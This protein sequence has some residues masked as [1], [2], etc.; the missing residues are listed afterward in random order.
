MRRKAI[1]FVIILALSLT[2]Q[3]QDEPL[4]LRNDAPL[5]EFISLVAND[6]G[7][8]TLTGA[9]G[10]V[11]TPSQIVVRNLHTGEFLFDA[12]SFD[13]SFETT[14]VGTLETPYQIN[15]AAS[16]PPNE[17]DSYTIFPGAGTIIQQ[18]PNPTIF[19]ASGELARGA[20]RWFAEG[21]LNRFAANV[22][23][24]VILRM[25][26]SLELPPD[27][28]AVPYTFIGE[29][30]LR[31]LTDEQGQQINLRDDLER[32][33]SS[34]LTETGIP[35]IAPLAPDIAIAETSTTIRQVDEE[36]DRLLFSLNFVGN[37]PS[38]ITQGFYVPI[39]RGRAAIADS[40]AFDW[41]DNLIFS[42]DGEGAVGDS[43]TYLPFV[44]R[45]GDVPE[46][47]TVWSVMETLSEEDKTRAELVN[48]IEH[49]P[50]LMI[51]PRGVYS[52][53]PRM[54]PFGDVLPMVPF[55][56]PSGTLQATVT[57]PDGSIDTLATDVPIRQHVV[58]NGQVSL[59]TLQENFSYDFDAYGDYTISLSGV[60]LD[61]FGNRYVGGGTYRITIAEPLTLFPSA[62]ASALFV[63]GDVVPADVTVSPAV[64]AEVVI[65]VRGAVG[66]TLQGQANRYGVF[67]DDALLRWSQLGNYVID[68]TARYSD[69]LGRLWAGSLRSVGVISTD[70]ILFGQR[71]LADEDSPTQAWFDTAIYPDDAFGVAPVVNYPYFPGDVALVPD[72][73]E[74]GIRP[75]FE[76]DSTVLFNVVRPD[77]SVRQ[78]I[79]ATGQ[80]LRFGNDE[81]LNN[82]IGAGGAGNA[83]GDI[84]FLF[85]ADFQ[86][87]IGYASA[88]IITAENSTARVLPPFRE[89]LLT[90]KDAPLDLL[91][92]PTALRAGQVVVQGE[93]RSIAGHVVPTLPADVT[94]RV[95]KPDSP[96]A[97]VPLQAN[98]FGYFALNDNVLFDQVGVWR[99][100][101]NAEF[102][103]QTS[104]GQILPPYPR[105]RVLGAEDDMFIFVVPP[106]A[107]PLNIRGEAESTVFPGQSF[108]IVADVPDGWI[109]VRAF[110]TARS[111]TYLLEQSELDVVGTTVSYRYDWNGL[112][113][114][115]PNLES[116]GAGDD[117]SASDEVTITVALTGIDSDGF[118]TATARVFTLRHNVLISNDG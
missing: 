6:D 69:E 35:I 75:A 96:A 1:I 114:Q 98:R 65:D 51:R 104:A 42:V 8:V 11:F 56:L 108:A 110:V 30:A 13:G 77:V 21:D 85:G 39:F 88:A 111:A 82:Q 37:L 25:D 105:G 70:A 109:D 40:D 26:F 38:E 116:T 71:G 61:I 4:G 45:V 92:V 14:L 32:G 107:P 90:L 68:Y 67:H 48:L 3:A 72:G 94:V 91:I 74:A 117:A 64:P 22:G 113:R 78:T 99:V 87:N 29:L 44:F 12:P 47:R 9:A 18:R 89:P 31:P 49:T 41:Y 23:D 17:R 34:T 73:D 53:E 33:W 58:E 15:V 50:A 52:L 59:S 86:N 100:G 63:V 62:L 93:R 97:E 101:L 76:S 7:T 102:R 27:A 10:S 57:R 95:S 36:S 28:L 20:S 106:D 43:A 80:D 54:L 24:E 55:S 19:T 83:A 16:F 66:G 103:G 2:L 79:I 118:P 84:L 46:I 112:A 81:A 115:F 5:A 60:L